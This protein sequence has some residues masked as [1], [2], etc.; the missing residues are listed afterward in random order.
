M[1]V[2][3]LAFAYYDDYKRKWHRVERI[4]IE[5]TGGRSGKVAECWGCG[6]EEFMEVS[7]PG[8]VLPSQYQITVT[9][10]GGLSASTG[11]VGYEQGETVIFVDHPL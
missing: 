5:E 11:H 3:V 7:L 10:Q 8:L 2:R 4:L 1:D 9:W 6:Y